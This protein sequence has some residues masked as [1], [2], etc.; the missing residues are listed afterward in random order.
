MSG[1]QEKRGVKKPEKGHNLHENMR[2]FHQMVL[3]LEGVYK[4][5]GGY[6]H[7]APAIVGSKIG[8][9]EPKN[10]QNLTL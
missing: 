1:E 9:K 2:P 8:S 5:L 6:I 3:Y 4:V 7:I 10:R